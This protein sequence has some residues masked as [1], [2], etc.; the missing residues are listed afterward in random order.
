MK[1]VTFSCANSKLSR[2]GKELDKISYKF[3]LNL[4]KIPTSHIKNFDLPAGWTCPAS[5]ICH[6]RF[7]PLTKVTC[8]GENMVFEC[9]AMRSERQYPSTALMRWNNYNTL[10]NCSS[11]DEMA[12]VLENS[13]PKN[14]EIVRIHA[15]GD[16]FNGT[17]F[18]AWLKVIEN[19][20]SIFFYAYTKVYPLLKKDIP[21]N[22]HL[23]YSFG[24]KW[25]ETYLLENTLDIPQCIIVE[26]ESQAHDLGLPVACKELEDDI[27]YIFLGQSF[28][29][30]EH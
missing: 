23:V 18:R 5:N 13:L 20:P 27:A 12:Q 11:A 22:F 25:D 17:Y 15:S 28:A 7:N 26:D 3:G 10:I 9:Y 21:D 14:V 16:F 29:L 8:R 30:I 4:S 2:M 19:H 24:G 1:S 6:A